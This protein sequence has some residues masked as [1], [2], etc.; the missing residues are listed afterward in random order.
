MGE[1]TCKFSDLN[2]FL[3]Y[4]ISILRLVSQLPLQPMKTFTTHLFFLSGLT[5]VTK[6]LS[7]H[8]EAYNM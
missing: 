4:L 6:R 5:G 3:F 8:G 2:K 1:L 7:V